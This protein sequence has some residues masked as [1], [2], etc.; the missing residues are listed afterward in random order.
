MATSTIP[1]IWKTSTIIPLLKPK[2]PADDSSS[3]R[4]VSLL[5]PGIKILERLLLPTLTNHLPVPDHQH[6]FRKAHSTVSALNDFNQRVADGF[7]KKKPP[8]R[9]V[10]LQIDLSKAFDMVSHEKLLKDLNQTT[11]PEPIKRWL[12]CYLHGRQSRV[13]F[14][15][16][17]S[18]ARN[19]KS[20]VPQGAVTSPLLFNFYISLLPVPPS[21]VYIVQYADDISVY[22]SGTDINKLTNNINIYIKKVLAFLGDRELEVSPSKSTV[23]LFTPDTKEA[24]IHPQVKMDNKVVELDKCPKLLGVH[25]DTM[26]TFSHHIKNTVAKA[27]TKVNILKALAG[28]SW[29]QDKETLVITY[30]SIGRSTLEYAAPIWTPTISQT[31][32][33]KLQTVQNQALRTATGNLAMSSSEHVHQECKMLPVKDHCTMISKQYLAACHQQNHPGNKHLNQNP[34]PRNL[35]PTI[36]SY[37]AEVKDKYRGGLYK[38]VLKTLH[39]AAV[40]STLDSYQPNRV[41][42]TKPPDINPEEKTLTRS[43]RCKLTR[44]RSG[45]CRSL[46]SYMSRIDNGI[47]DACPKCDSSPHDT[48]H[49]FNC[50]ADPT[51]LTVIDL[52]T[53]PILAAEFLGLTEDDE[54]TED[55]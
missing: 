9:T 17:T 10:L 41:L 35:K 40:K 20:G 18:S 23:T 53:R 13:Q 28:S 27:K 3:Y 7:N 8:D 33:N 30:K 5:C 15:N 55:P 43:V 51:N 42:G 22:S 49:L 6:G 2:K 25:F 44:L 26:Y 12:N 50:H 34:Q 11:L 37:E 48:R 54:P 47:T 52:W 31:S 46:N 21:G 4:P 45:F 32:W 24:K 36:L 38:D 16:E 1:S 14:R 39:T 19:V 29:G